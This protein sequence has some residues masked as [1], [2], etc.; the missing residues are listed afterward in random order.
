MEMKMSESNF[1]SLDEA[2]KAIRD[3]YSDLVGYYTYEGLGPHAF[4]RAVA[5]VMDECQIELKEIKKR[6]NKF[7][8]DKD[9]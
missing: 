4:T 9:E 8:G 6:I 2:K 5:I 7:A 1:N 3:A